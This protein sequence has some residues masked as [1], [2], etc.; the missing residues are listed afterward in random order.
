[1][2]KIWGRTNSVNVQKV[3]WCLD[4][5]DVPCERVDAGLKYG[6]N[7]EPWYL[8]L[9]PNGRVPLLQDSFSLGINTIVRYLASKHGLAPMLSARDARAWNG[10]WLA[11][12]SAREPRVDR[13]LEPDPHA[14]DR[15]GPLA[16]E[17]D[18]GRTA[19]AILVAI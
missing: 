8:E 5:L 6:K 11:A 1:V 18:E 17:V 9:N 7:D 19:C 4:E 14:G 2:V 16:V 15:A 10:G 3:L 13:V 12:L